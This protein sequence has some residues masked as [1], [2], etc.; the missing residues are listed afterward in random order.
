M[1]LF[2]SGLLILVAQIHDVFQG[3]VPSTFKE[4]LFII[5]GTVSLSVV[6]KIEKR[7]M[8]IH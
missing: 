8:Y 6:E 3:R 5:L 4:A 7:T 1:T 2:L